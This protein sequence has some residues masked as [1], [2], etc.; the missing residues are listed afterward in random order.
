MCSANRKVF[1]CLVDTVVMISALISKHNNL[2]S[3]IW[4]FTPLSWLKRTKSDYL[5]NNIHFKKK[6][7][8]SFKRCSRCKHKTKQLNCNSLINQHAKKT[9]TLKKVTLNLPPAHHYKVTYPV[10][11]EYTFCSH[12]LPEKAICLVFIMTT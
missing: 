3:P 9:A 2:V 6:V 11:E 7:S 12:L 8:H 1:Y 10:C 5:P 4:K